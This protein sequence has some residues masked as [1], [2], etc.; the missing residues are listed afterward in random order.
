MQP[1][2]LRQPLDRGH[3]AAVGHNGQ[4]DA[5]THLLSIEQH[6]AGAADT[7]TTAFFG[8][9][10]AQVVAQKINQQP[11]VRNLS[12]H[13]SA[14]HSQLYRSHLLPSSARS[15][16]YPFPAVTGNSVSRPPTASKPALA[17]AAGTA[18]LLNS[19]TAL[20]A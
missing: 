10:E 3:F 18:T 20:P 1:V 13:G 8:A 6:R 7:H 2:I 12:G 9:G 5:G 17:T 4:G 15:P 14:I 16:A 19:P 11:V